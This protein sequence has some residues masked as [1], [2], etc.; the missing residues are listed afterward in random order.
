MSIISALPYTLQNGNNADASQVMADFNQIRDDVNNN[1]GTGSLTNVATGAGLTGGP[2]TT[3]GTISIANGTANSLMGYNN[4]AAFGV[5]TLGTGLSLVSGV[6]T[7]N[8]GT[9]FATLTDVVVDTGHNNMWAVNASVLGATSANQNTGFGTHNFTALTTGIGNTT[10][11]AYGLQY[12][13]TGSGNSSFGNG[14]LNLVDVGSNNTGLGQNA[15]SIVVDG[16]RN[17]LIG[18]SADVDSASAANR[19]AIGYTAVCTADNS[20]QIGNASVTDVR[21]GN[22]TS[23]VLHAGGVT[24]NGTNT[25]KL[26]AF[27][28]TNPQAQAGTVT[29]VI[30]GVTVTLLTA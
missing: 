19:I 8:G 17:T 12:I 14:A 5:V 27:N 4:G 30:N 7:S 11:G 24:T 6:L 2:I 28:A 22:P 21:F 20:A 26:G 1:A 29:V 13:S 3:T 18:K 25:W 15:G 16:I 10:F 9:T 23:T